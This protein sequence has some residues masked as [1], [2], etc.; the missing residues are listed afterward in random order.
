MPW[1]S[2]RT[3]AAC[4]GRWEGALVPAQD[5]PGLWVGQRGALGRKPSAGTSEG[6]QHHGLFV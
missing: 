3:A 4:L 5:V 1:S 2:S 6:I